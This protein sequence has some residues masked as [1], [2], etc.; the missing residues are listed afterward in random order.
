MQSGTAEPGSQGGSADPPAKIMEE[1]K[2]PVRVE[3]RA[4]L[5]R[6]SQIPRLMTDPGCRRSGLF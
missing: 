4:G 6:A 1:G 5:V 3:N 2:K